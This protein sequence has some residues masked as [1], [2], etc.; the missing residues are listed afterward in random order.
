MR[1]STVAEISFP[2]DATIDMFAKPHPP[3]A[4]LLH[5]CVGSSQTSVDLRL[6]LLLLFNVFNSQQVTHS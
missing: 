1:L 2:D 3:P 5:I 4:H 6:M